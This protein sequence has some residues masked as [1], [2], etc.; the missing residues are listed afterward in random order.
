MLYWTRRLGQLVGWVVDMAT[1]SMRRSA[2]TELLRRQVPV[3]NIMAAGRWSNQRVCFDYMRRGETALAKAMPG[4][5]TSIHRAERW[6]L[7][8]PEALKL[9]QRL[10]NDRSISRDRIR[11]RR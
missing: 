1:H 6:C 4:A 9:R 8:A 11:C 3:P 10:G 5:A 2:A 7:L